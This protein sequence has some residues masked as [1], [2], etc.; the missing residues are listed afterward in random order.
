MAVAPA[1]LTHCNGLLTAMEQNSSDW[2]TGGC[3]DQWSF[4]DLRSMAG[5]LAS[6]TGAGANTNHALGEYTSGDPGADKVMLETAN[7]L[8]LGATGRFITFSLDATAVNCHVTHP[9]YAFSALDGASTVPMYDNPIDACDH[10]G[11]AT[12]TADTAHLSSGPTVGFRIVNPHGGGTG[13][14]SAAPAR[15]TSRAQ[16]AY[17][18]PAVPA[19]SSR[20]P[21]RPPAPRRARS[22]WAVWCC[23][24]PAC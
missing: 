4:D 13:N 3:G 2:I 14:D 22:P 11:P 7:P 24:W 16:R 9:W 15:P 23:C 10:S 6:L 1:W 21:F 19:W 20:S 18:R 17:S 5:A 8:A 12:Y